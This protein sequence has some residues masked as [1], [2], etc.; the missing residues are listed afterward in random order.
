[1]YTAVCAMGCAK[2]GGGGGGDFAAQAVLDVG[3]GAASC[4]AEPLLHLRHAGA[5][6]RSCST[7][8][9]P[10]EGSTAPGKDRMRLG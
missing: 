5:L 3:P 1:M 10:A 2:R 8:L 7:A 6:V 9:L 4:P